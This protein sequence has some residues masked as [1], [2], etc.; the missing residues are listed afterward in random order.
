[1]AAH[2]PAK[3]TRKR[4][5]A[6]DGDRW[7]TFDGCSDD[8]DEEDVDDDDDEDDKDDDEEKITCII[9]S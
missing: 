7:L 9:T 4:R 1:M 6:V 2:W 8:D 3:W 5:W